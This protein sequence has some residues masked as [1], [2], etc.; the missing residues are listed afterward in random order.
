MSFS[1]Q[2]AL[3][4]EFL[5]RLQLQLGQFK[6]GRKSGEEALKIFIGQQWAGAAAGQGPND[7]GCTQNCE[8]R[9]EVVVWL[10]ALAGGCCRSSVPPGCRT[11]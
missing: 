6:E 5:A 10:Q 8:G 9:C 1:R 3:E 7:A 4:L 11:L 2:E